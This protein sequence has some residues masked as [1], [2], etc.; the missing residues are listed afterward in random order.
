M[1]FKEDFGFFKTIFVKYGRKS[2]MAL[3][4]WISLKL[5]ICNV[6]QQRRFLI[7][8]R[9]Y[10]L[11][12][13]HIHNLRLN[14]S[15]RDH[16]VNRR[17]GNLRKNFRLKLLNLEIR[18]I[19]YEIGHLMLKLKNLE[20]LLSSL[21]PSDILNN[22]FD[23]NINRIRRHNLNCKTKLIDKFN[24]ISSA[25]IAEVNNFFMVDNQKWVVNNSNKI[26]PL[27]VMNFLSLGEK[28][29][30]PLDFNNSKDR[31][32]TTLAFV[33]NF[34]ASSYKIPERV[35]DKV[36]SSLVNTLKKNLQNN[37]HVNY[38]DARLQ[39]EY[40]SCKRFL[41]NNEDIFVTKADKG[42]VTVILDKNNYIKQMESLL[43]DDSTYRQIKKNP[44]RKI[45]VKID[46]MIKAWR[47]SKII[48][49]GAYKK[50]KCTNG[51][52]PRCYGLP[53]I[54]KPGHPLR[55]IVSSLGSPLYD[56]AKSL[57]KLLSD[58]LK[59][60]ASHVKDGWTFAR[61]ITQVTVDTTATMVS[62]DATSLFTNIP[63]ELVIRAIECRWT[64]I[65]KNTKLSLN[66]LIYAI[67]LILG[68]TSFA[69]NDRF[70]EQIHGSPMGSPLSPILAD[71]V[72]EDLEVTCLNN[73]DF[74][75]QVFYR[76][77]DDIF[78]I[79]PITKL[80]Q[81]LTNFNNYH[82]RLKF[83]Y[84]IEHDNTL[85][86]L[87]TSVIRTSNNTLITNWYKKPTFSGRFINFYSSHPYVYKLNTIKTLVDQ[88]ILL[89]DEQFHAGNLATVETILINNGYPK[90][91]AT[92]EI[93]KR[94][95]FLMEDLS[96]NVKEK[97]S[98]GCDN[99]T[100]ILTLPY[101]RKLSDDVK[102]ILKNMVDVRFTLPKK[103]D[104]IIR[105]G[106]D[107]LEAGRVTEV[108]Y[109]IDCKNCDKVYIGQ[110]KRHLSTR[111]NEHK[112]NI[113]NTTGN[114]SVV[115]EHRIKFDH[116]FDWCKPNILHNERNRRKREIAEMF[117]IKKFDNNINLQRDT[118]NLNVVYD[119]II[120]S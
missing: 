75:V 74:S 113:R 57:N 58:S 81:V 19:H 51:N 52:L 83:T 20:R 112:N 90:K 91:M 27:P 111:I 107:R 79:I 62:L 26:I 119:N 50:L 28:F 120:I 13:P 55:I 97:V 73:L 72:M 99:L 31:L 36:R 30:L 88:A 63:K 92:K 56:I 116:D 118:E 114:L 33:K 23:S 15:M 4:D 60:P 46:N 100:S 10:D 6:K 108:V 7:R 17:F 117:Y 86:F 1:W 69:F 34:E 68:S 104:S 45:T 21:L 82:P 67:D 18:D 48:D 35:V 94:Y 40:I 49:E 11:L 65:E 80:N 102:R 24:K 110:T 93:N 25:R 37:K 41:K 22:F 59:K 85:N 9:S 106:K 12:P 5:K 76:Y 66:Q 89:S 14:I 29:A 105:R 101:V 61:C 109:K 38:I 71:L 95:A 39:K 64:D 53:K 98:S 78:M 16:R 54:H 47:D 77:V 2:E 70:Y 42:Q 43:N 84:E 44:L 3:K 96:N 87:N 32:D 8:C 103:L 115:S